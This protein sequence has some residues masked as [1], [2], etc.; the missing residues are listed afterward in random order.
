MKLG[1]IS[2]AQHYYTANG[3]LCAL[4]IV[5]RQFE[6]WAALFDEVIVCAP[7]MMGLPPGTHSLY[8][9]TNIRLLP[10]A[11]AGGN[12]LQAKLGMARQFAGWWR[13]LQNL[14]RQV[15]AVHIRCPNNISILGLLAL[16]RTRLYRQ[17][18]Y[19]G[20]WNG[21]TGEPLTYR[22]QRYFLRHWF[23]G[24][25]AVYGEWPG[26]PAHLV[27]SFSPSYTQADWDAESTQVEDRLNRLK[28]LTA[29]QQPLH[30]LSIGLLNRNK[31]QQ[32]VIR[33]LKMLTERG[34]QAELHLLGDGDQRPTLKTL[35]SELGI[36]ERVYF[37]GA[38]PHD[39]VRQAY[40]QA[41]FVVQAPHAEGYGKVPIEAFFHGVVPI[42]SDVGMSAQIVGGTERGACYPFDN[43]AA[44]AA[45]ILELATDPSEMV[46]RIENGR[47]YAR[48]HTLDAWQQHIRQM[49]ENSWGV[50]LS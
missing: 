18:V 48:K 9:T 40:R 42:L 12:S 6:Q 45:A 38:Q 7:L 1:I 19:T 24:P 46:R 28:M 37:D 20:T 2:D 29:L 32:M 47:Q 36:A 17:A 3:Q 16:Q 10:I 11:K 25:V 13:S 5:V 21:Y 49:C 44:A 31:N 43:A 23:K 35:G 4:E 22:W 30:L 33:M 39:V 8:R 27:P 50:H 26:Q 41:D 34:W 14:F 15:D